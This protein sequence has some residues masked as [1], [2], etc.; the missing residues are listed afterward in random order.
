[1]KSTTVKLL[2]YILSFLLAAIGTN[3]QQITGIWK[4]KVKSTNIE[5][6]IVKSGDSLTGSAYYYQ[7]KNNFRHYSIRGYFDAASND[8]IWWDDVLLEGKGAMAN[9]NAGEP[10]LSAADFNCPGED[11]ML[12]DGNS[13]ER[14]NKDNIKGP[15]HLQK[16]TTSIF[17][18]EWDWVIDNYTAGAN[19]PNVIDSVTQLV[20]GPRY[21]PEEKLPEAVAINGQRATKKD[22]PV[23]KSP[24]T[25][26]EAAPVVKK[27]GTNEE[28][29]TS[30]QN[31]L[32][33]VIPVTASTIELRF[34]DNAAIDGDSI[35]IFLNG[36]VV[37]EHI[38][39][40]G[41]PQ[42]IKIN[43]DDLQDDNELVMVAEN[44]GSIPP[45]TSYLVAIVGK[46][47]YEARLFA[48]EGTSALIRLVKPQG[49]SS[50]TRDL[51]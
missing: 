21:Y 48:D 1:M 8:V 50:F 34:Y 46:K 42:I 27:M 13:S 5:L 38:L 22:I 20:A 9:G 30:R 17:P 49:K 23:I 32:Q 18:D 29:F 33:M 40:G 45:N 43:A 3:A 37:R 7:S 36:K 16:V 15:V 35:A 25:P 44:L 41:E 12:L 11:K 26:R 31:K 24:T 19:D 6:K 2:T 10:L 39:L 51:P 4:G 14:D 47:Q 28:K